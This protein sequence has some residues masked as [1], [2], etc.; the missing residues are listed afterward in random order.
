MFLQAGQRVAIDSVVSAFENRAMFDRVISLILIA[1]VA[2]CPM[3]CCG[4]DCCIDV[5]TDD[6]DSIASQCCCCGEAASCGGEAGRDSS[7]SGPAQ[8]PWSG[9]DDQCPDN[10]SCQCLC[11]GA[12]VAKVCQ[13]DDSRPACCFRLTAP[14]G[15]LGFS[16]PA[17]GCGVAAD[18]CHWR[19]ARNPGRVIRTLHCSLLC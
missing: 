11:G 15:V 5:Q 4:G 8:A 18:P 9:D 3:M 13:P 1:V 16:V 2:V 19:S 10:R 6:V 17:Q 12:V 14:D 7:A